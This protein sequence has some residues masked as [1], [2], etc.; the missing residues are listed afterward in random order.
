MAKSVNMTVDGTDGTYQGVETLGRRGVDGMPMGW[1]PEDETSMGAL[2]ATE[3][4]LYEPSGFYAYSKANV[5]VR[6]G[7]AAYVEVEQPDGSV[8]VEWVVP[9][10]STSPSA[11]GVVGVD[12]T[13]GNSYYVYVGDD[14]MLH[15]VKVPSVATLSSLPARTEYEDGDEMD[16]TGAAIALAYGD[17]TAATD[18]DGGTVAFG[19]PEWDVHVSVPQEAL[20]AGQESVTVHVLGFWLRGWQGLGEAYGLAVDIPIEVA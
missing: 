11:G 9:E 12:R 6:G 18:Y 3:N 19:T 7:N 16:Y 13:D 8:R 15:K 10:P 2:R 1:V 14:G 4:G 5:L 17:G 20:S